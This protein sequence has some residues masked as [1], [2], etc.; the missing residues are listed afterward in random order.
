MGV[1]DVEGKE[2]AVEGEDVK[3]T[4]P[5]SNTGKV[6]SVTEEL[7][8]EERAKE[9]GRGG[10]V[11]VTVTV[12][13]KTHVEVDDRIV[14]PFTWTEGGQVCVGDIVIKFGGENEAGIGVTGGGVD[15]T[16]M[17]E[18]AAPRGR[19]SWGLGK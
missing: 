18:W 11:Q 3:A 1:V 14:D 16:S 6:V 8:H 9:V 12:S 4:S 19:F 5:S 10:G 17:K 7:V 2:D 15:A 13:K